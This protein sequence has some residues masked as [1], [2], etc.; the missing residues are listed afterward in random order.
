M[1]GKK[2]P[3][4]C[5]T[6]TYH[7]YSLD[8]ALNGIAQA[9]FRYVELSAVP[10]WTEHVRL[11][12][13]PSDVRARVES[14]GLKPLSMSAHSDLTTDDGISYLL[15]AIPFASELGVRYV[16]TAIGG[17]ASLDEDVHAFLARTADIAS[18]ADRFDMI[19]TLE[20]HGSIM[21]SG[22]DSLAIIQ[23]IQSPRVRVNYDTGNVRFYGG[24]QPA[25]DLPKIM[26]F[27]AHMHLKDHIGGKA[28]WQFPALGRGEVA[29]DGVFETLSGYGYQGPI[30][31][32]I[33]FEGEPWPALADVDHAVAVSH[34]FLVS[35]GY[36]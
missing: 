35:H 11:T 28:N 6:N 9:G 36:A 16:N 21:A 14:F 34:E 10:G 3:V 30:S 23:K 29:F 33:E 13:P 1:A 7:T 4:A 32:E 19:V 20:T 27:V 8:E 5:S 31:V 25:E 18:A 22:A 12:D 17:H 24:Q 15:Q 2:S 26:D